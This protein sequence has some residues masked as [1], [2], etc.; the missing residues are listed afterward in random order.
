MRRAVKPGNSRGACALTCASEAA[1]EATTVVYRKS[2]RSSMSGRIVRLFAR[3]ARHA[4]VPRRRELKQISSSLQTVLILRTGRI[5]K[6]CAP[7]V[8]SVGFRGASMR[9]L[10]VLSLLVFVAACSSPAPAPTTPAAPAAAAPQVKG[11]LN[12]VMRGILFPNSNILFDAQDK[13]PAAK[14]DPKDP[15][16]AAHPFAGTYGGWEAVENASIAL[17]E[18]ANLVA[19]P[20]R[21]CANGKPVPLNDPTFQKGLA[22][23]RE[24]S[25]LAYK[26]AMEKKQDAMLDV[27]DKL[28]MAC[29]TCH[30][31]YR[32]I[33]GPDGKPAGLEA[34]C[35]PKP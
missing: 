23:L 27:A 15:A 21:N 31:V 10:T 34:R 30:D 1:I 29:A 9:V 8:N 11:T 14:P 24:V 7:E 19:L 18:A 32:D 35:N 6:S 13:D 17:A 33:N 28:T 12:Q 25:M 3:Q 4:G 22:A 5:Q 20:G 2:R 16:A 26:T